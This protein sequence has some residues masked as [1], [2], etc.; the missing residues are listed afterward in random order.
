[1]VPSRPAVLLVEAL[2]SV[3]VQRH[4]GNPQKE[5]EKEPLSEGLVII[6]VVHIS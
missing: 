4:S 1:M 2:R 6:P 5:T 3:S